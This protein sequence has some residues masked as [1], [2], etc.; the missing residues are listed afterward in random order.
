MSID[1]QAKHAAKSIDDMRLMSWMSGMAF[2]ILLAMVAAFLIFIT[3]AA[4]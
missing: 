4:S 2:G 1:D 3:R